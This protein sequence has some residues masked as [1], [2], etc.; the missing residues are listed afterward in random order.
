MKKKTKKQWTYIGIA[1]AV[2]GVAAA[3]CFWP[4]EVQPTI[5]I[6]FLKEGKLAAVERRA[7]PAEGTLKQAIEALLAGPAAGEADYSTLIPLKT[8]LLNF[9]IQGETASLNFSRELENYGGGAA[10]VEGLIAQIVY[11]ATEIRGITKVWLWLAGQKE[12]VLGGEGLVLDRPLGR[13][14]IKL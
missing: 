2:M 3:Y 9:R 11:T 6:Y 14:S 5:K 1:L 12:V 10:R 8:R 7:D 4:W 13:E